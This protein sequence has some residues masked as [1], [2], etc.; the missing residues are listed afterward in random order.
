VIDRPASALRELM[1]NAIDAGAT[2]IKVSISGGGIDAIT[3]IDNGCGMPRE[4]L[5]VCIVEHSTSKIEKA[6]DLLT[7]R[8][9]GFRG[10][11]L[12]SMAAVARIELLSRETSSDSGWRLRKEPGKSLSLAQSAARPGTSVLLKGLFESF[13]ARRQFLKRA[14]AEANLCR[15]TFMER[16]LAN[17]SISFSWTSGDSPEVFLP[18]DLSGRLT[19]VYRDIPDSALST[20][21]LETGFARIAIVYADPSF[22]RRDRKYLQVFVNRRK[23]PEWGLQSVMEYSFSEYLPGGMRPVAF[24]FA[25]VDPAY[26]DFN[27]H[28]AKREVRIKDIES[29]KTGFYQAFREHLRASLRGGPTDMGISRTKPADTPLP[30]EFWNRLAEARESAEEKWPVFPQDTKTETSPSPFRYLGPAFGP[31]LVFEKDAELYIMDQHAA[32]ERSIYDRLTARDT[33]SQP[34]LVPFVLEPATEA[35]MRLL[36]A[37]VE[38]L[39]GLGY[40]LAFEGSEIMVEGIPSI[41]GDQA[42]PA[43]MEWLSNGTPASDAANGIAATAACRAAVKDGDRLDETAARDLISGALALPF[44]RCPHGRPIWAKLTRELLDRMVGRAGT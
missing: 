35:A 16:A 39:S 43:L 42:L 20:F 40:V 19:Q 21:E 8:T 25:E 23:V 26:A 1:D 22:H 33:V 14:S 10:E 36:K 3:V 24:M 37:S 32:H 11:A 15:Q 27:I 7:A 31:Y 17:P 30:P 12:A 41:L 5:E 9:L 13:P 6:D 18:V 44:P 4:D 2:E 29:L 38:E 28:P 34:L